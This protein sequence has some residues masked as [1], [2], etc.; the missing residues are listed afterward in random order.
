MKPLDP[1]KTAF[2]LA[3]LGGS[4]RPRISDLRQAV[5]AIY[6]AYFHTLCRCVADLWVGASP[7]ARASK[8]SDFLI[9][10]R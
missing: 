10:P 9:S 2:R 7:A 5:V 4:K 6:F 1:I 3:K 8:A